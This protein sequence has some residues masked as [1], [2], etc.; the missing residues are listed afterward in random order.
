MQ[1]DEDERAH[2]GDRMLGMAIWFSLAILGIIALALLFN[3]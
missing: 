1:F 3:R 2:Y